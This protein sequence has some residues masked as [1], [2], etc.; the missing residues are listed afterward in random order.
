[1]SFE[2]GALGVWT[3]N[4]DLV[5]AAQ[6]ADIVAELEQIGYGAV[7]VPEAVGREAFTN[8]ALLLRGGER[9]VVGTG[10]ASIWMRHP[11]AASAAHKALSE[12]YPNR[13]LLGLGVSHAPMVDGVLGAHYE[14]PL[15]AMRSYLDGMDNSIFAATPPP[16]EAPPRRVLAAL[17]PKMQSLAAARADG[18]L[19][20][21]VAPEHTADA[22]AA[23]GDG[24]LL[25]VEQAVVLSTDPDEARML[26][27][28]HLAIYM[29]LPNYSR[30]WLRYGM[31]DDDLSDGGS[32]RLVDHVVAWGDEAA[33]AQRVRAHRDAG[34]DHV[35]L[36][37][38]NAD[39]GRV[40]M[41]EWRRLVE[42]IG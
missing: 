7:W 12:A 26:G 32:D 36:Q 33:V 40:P 6:G 37:V 8:A 27:R 4:L 13:F 9:I 5:P 22:R 25:A 3:F 18:A 20:Y 29:G 2:V 39:Q 17:G 28:R 11:M 31:T 1:M 21:N 30:N 10:I 38:I 34:A 23:L 16:A 15:S 35:C 41:E 14:K 19:T 24:P 42:A